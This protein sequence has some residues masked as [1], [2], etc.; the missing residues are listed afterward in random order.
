MD[1]FTLFAGNSL[2]LVIFSIAFAA[3]A[4]RKDEP[5]WRTWMISNL[6]L[7]AALLF[8]MIETD[9]PD[10]A[11]VALPNSL[12][13]AGFGF[14]W[15]A[16]R[17][18]NGRG[19][20]WI[21]AGV[22]FAVFLALIA[23]PPI[24]QSYAAAY[25]IVNGLLAGLAFASGYE[26]FR[27]RSDGLQSRYALTAAYMLM[28]MSFAVRAG[29]GIAAS[30]MMERQLP[31]DLILTLHLFVALIFTAGGGAFS[32]S[33]AFERNAAHLRETASRDALTGLYNRGAFERRVNE[34]LKGAAARDFALAVF[35]L[36]HF[37]QINDTFGHDAG[38]RA[39]KAFAGCCRSVLRDGDVAARVGGEEFAV[40]MP[41]TE[42][43]EALAVVERVRLALSRTG[44]DTE[45]G[46]LRMTVS[47][48][49]CQSAMFGGDYDALM[50]R[51]DQYLYAAKDGGRDQVRV[52]AA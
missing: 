34:W 19:Y 7:T 37:K 44:I 45:R 49:I 13:L 33:V 48:G 26:F 14:R 2:V 8:Y 22:P 41:L 25:T 40:L 4:Q 6:V 51:A 11:I 5:Y 46:T 39:L 32:L 23:I 24:Y 31:D 1:N 42:P 43:A 36:D 9:L 16:A 47:A 15:V 30:A 28:G 52:E 38:D 50:R 17:Q 10:W 35:D 18:F 29:Q 27:D 21:A 20:S 3:A 12:L